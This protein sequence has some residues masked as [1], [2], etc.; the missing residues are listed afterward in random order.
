MRRNGIART[1]AKE[2]EREQG[3]GVAAEFPAQRPGR[4]RLLGG[5]HGVFVLVC[6]EAGRPSWVLMASR[7][8]N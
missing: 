5:F 1:D 3:D 2:E 6:G 4:G 7:G 8:M